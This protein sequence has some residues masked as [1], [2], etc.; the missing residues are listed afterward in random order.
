M[1]RK[2]SI[3]E[4]RSKILNMLHTDG[5][6]FVEQLVE[7]F[8]V[9]EVSIRK[10]LAVLEE[11]KLLVRVKGGAIILHQTDDFDDM[12][13]SSK[14]RLH[15]REK[16]LIGKYAA[17]MIHDGERIIFD[18]GTTT[19]EVA[20]NL[21]GFNHL[22]I[23]TN[24]LDI[25]ITL[26]NYNRFTVIVLGGTMRAVSHSTVGMISESALKNIFCDKLF[27]GVD[28]IS[29][30]DGLS[31][32]SLEEAS[33]NQAMIGAAKE[34]IA[35]FDS[36]K[37]GRRTFAHIASLD[38]WDDYTKAKNAMFEVSDTVDCPWTVVKS[39][40]KKR[41]RLNA[42]RY[43]LNLIPYDNRDDSVVGPTDPLIVGRA[44]SMIEAQESLK[45]LE[46]MRQ[47]QVRKHQAAYEQAEKVANKS[48]HKAADKAADEEARA[49][50]AAEKEAR[51]AAKV[52]EK[53]AKAAAKVAEKEARAAEKQAKA[54]EKAA[55]KEAKAA[56]KAAEKEAKTAEKNAKAKDGKAGK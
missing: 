53:E 18:S 41:A 44:T 32:P 50:K 55:E 13:I 54:A 12:S 40:D 11:R 3:E 20:K 24:A 28:S 4:R 19:M 47:K 1:K 9:S 22:T 56:A 33:L 30:K 21:E 34:V 31:T 27:L 36:S 42:M 5:R 35:V 29:I 23:I 6:V 10:D 39:D 49:A 48:A 43:V 45:A 14:Q 17:S 26:N 15:A 52:A 38:K 25:A 16:Q 51:A 8:D 2:Y 7:T 37:F 46:Q